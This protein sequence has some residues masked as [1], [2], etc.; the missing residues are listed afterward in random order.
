MIETDRLFLRDWR[1]E[2]IAALAAINADPKVMAFFPSTETYE[3]TADAISRSRVKKEKFGFC[4]APAE[5]QQTGELIG[6]VG[7]NQVNFEAHFTPAVE[8]GWRLASRFWGQGLA[9]EAARAWLDEG[10]TSFDLDRIVSFAVLANA[11][12]IAVMK[13]IGMSHVDNGDFD[14]PALPADSPI[15][16]HTLYEKRRS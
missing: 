12:S 9:T 13:R 2:D 11:P 14:H 5:L 8:I 6:F 10:F 4:F 3:E 1:D 16:R 15:L 7:L